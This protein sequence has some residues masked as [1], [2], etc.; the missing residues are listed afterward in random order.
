[1]TT[2]PLTPAPGL[3]SPSADL[4]TARRAARLLALC[5]VP[6]GLWRLAMAAQLPVGYTPE[7]LREVYGIP[8]WGVAYVVGLTVLQEC[9]A[10]L[11]LLVVTGRLRVPNP[12]V[13]ART[14]RVLGW[15]MGLFCLSQAV[16]LFFVTPDA[17]LSPSGATVML[18]LYAPLAATGPLLAVAARAYGRHHA[19]HH[20][21]GGRRVTASARA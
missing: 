6:S 4:R 10:L 14:G 7:V 12:R 17:H 1:M 8:G 13:A 3:R 16:L 15:L 5:T 2:R 21:A 9:A 11:P 19:R 20:G 18:V